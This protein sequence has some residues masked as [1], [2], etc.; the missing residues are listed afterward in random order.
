MNAIAFPARTLWHAARVGLTDFLA[1]YTWYAWTFGWL[2]RL[3]FQVIFFTLVGRLVGGAHGAYILVGNAVAVAGIEGTMVILESAAERRSGTL[4]L[5]MSTPGSVV[6]AV[7]GRGLHWPV[8]GMISSS[9]VFAVVLPTFHIIPSWPRLVLLIPILLVVSFGTYCYGAV[10]GAVILRM[11]SIRWLALN[12]SYLTFMAISGV[13]VPVEDW[14]RPVQVVADT[15]P[16]TY[17]LLAVR[18]LLNGET[19]APLSRQLGIEVIVSA[20]WLAAA[21][22]LL[23][24]FA[25]SARANGTIDFAT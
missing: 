17:G 8:N 6:T 22:L 14:P 10:A 4:P 2:L 20:G 13:N 1:I 5:I 15:L 18:G 25:R 24:S 3:V 12:V 7:L 19:A 23:H 11:P 9:I 16:L 21:V